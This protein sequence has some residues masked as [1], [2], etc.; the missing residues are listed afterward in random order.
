MQE[1]D[2]GGQIDEANGCYSTN[3]IFDRCGEAASYAV[4]DSGIEVAAGARGNIEGTVID[5]ALLN[6][7]KTYLPVAKAPL[8]MTSNALSIGDFGDDGTAEGDGWAGVLSLAL[9]Y[10]YHISTRVRVAPMRIRVGWAGVR[11]ARH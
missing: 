4:G 2:L 8:G 6:K 3:V 7:L 11:P 5:N 1:K 10:C 9:M